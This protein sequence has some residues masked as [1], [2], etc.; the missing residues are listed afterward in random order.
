VGIAINHRRRARDQAE[1]Q[2]DGL[3][4]D[5]GLSVAYHAGQFRLNGCREIADVL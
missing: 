3:S 5:R 2:G 1:V 4:V